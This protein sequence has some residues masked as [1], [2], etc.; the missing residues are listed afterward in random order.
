M[1]DPQATM[2]AD[3]QFLAGDHGVHTFTNGVMLR[4][5]GT[6][7]ITVTDTNNSSITGSTN[8]N[9]SFLPASH[10]VFRALV[11]S[12]TPGE[13]F[14]VD[15]VALDQYGNT[16]TSY[17]GTVHFSSSDASATL[18]ADYTF[19]GSENGT[20]F[21]DQSSSLR[22]IGAQTLSITDVSNSSVSGQT[23][24]TDYP[25]CP[26]SPTRAVLGAQF[27]GRPP[28]G[29]EDELAIV[30]NAGVCVMY[31]GVGN[32]FR[33]PE[34]W[35]GP[36]YGTRATLAADVNSDGLVDL[37]AVNDSSTF[38]MRSFGY[39]FTAPTQ[40]SGQPFYGARATFAAD[41]TGTGKASLVAVNDTSTWVMTSTGSTFSASAEW[42]NQPFYGSRATLMTDAAQTGK[43]DLVAVNDSST[44]V[45]T[46]NGISFNAPAQWSSQPFYGNVATT[47]P[48]EGIGELV[49]VNR[50]GAWIMSSTGSAFNAPSPAS[51]T[52]FYGN[53][54]TLLACLQGGTSVP[55]LVAVNG[56][57]I[58]VE[59]SFGGSF[60]APAQWANSVP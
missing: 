11:A 60:S 58:W 47:A 12:T 1:D 7:Q 48:L 6:D 51:S 17:A 27:S 36:F 13:L 29:L 55:D 15:A 2:P 9:V 41:V 42:S 44:W 14:G 25:T 57:S 53:Q 24:V 31:V 19:T 40:W 56:S 21:W 3:Y 22:A 52:A 18:R 34:L 16:V 49:A 45:M 30:T 4:T 20:H 10:F 26:P 50:G 8:V 54:A 46:S 37:I 35:T 5:A 43:R 28:I 38:V 33:V 59:P 23:S 39:G 32:S